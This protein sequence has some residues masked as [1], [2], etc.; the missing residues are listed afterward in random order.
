MAHKTSFT[1]VETDDADGFEIKRVEINTNSTQGTEIIE[2]FG[3]FCR[4]IGL[5]PE[6]LIE[7][8][9]QQETKKVH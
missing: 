2:F 1:Y 6:T 9:E 4:S 3:E 5:D 7:N 8:L